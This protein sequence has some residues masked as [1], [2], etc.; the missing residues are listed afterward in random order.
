MKICQQNRVGSHVLIHFL[1]YTMQVGI[2]KNFF[3]A[4]VF[5]TSSNYYPL[6]AWNQFQ[7]IWW[8]VRQI[9]N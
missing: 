5:D 8:C 1:E 7:I 2:V 3:V 9:K 4:V 6:K